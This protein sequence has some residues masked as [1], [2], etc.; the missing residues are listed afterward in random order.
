MGGVIGD[1]LPLAVGVAICP[2]PII[3]RPHSGDEPAPPKWLTA[4]DSVTPVK[5]TG[6][7]VALAAVNP[8]N[9]LMILGAGVIIGSAGLP[10]GQIVGVVLIGKGIGSL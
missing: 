9:L 5:A 2:L 7:G 3:A 4:I 6:L 8:K 10:I 1:V